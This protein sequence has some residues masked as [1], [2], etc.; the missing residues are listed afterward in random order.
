MG[1]ESAIREL[2]DE[3]PNTIISASAG[4]SKTFALSNLYLRLLSSG[5]ECQTIL[6]TTFTK[7]GAGEILDRIMDRLSDAALDDNAAAGLS[8]ELEWQLTQPQ[9]ATALHQL[10]KN[11]HRLE[12]GTLDS[13]FNRIAKLFSLELGLPPTWEIVEEQQ[14][15][16]LHDQAIQQVLQD[17][18]V[19]SLLHMLSKGE[20]AR[21]VATL[22]HDT[23]EQVYRI[24]RESGPAPW[25]RLPK[26]G[27]FLTDGQL[28]NVLARMESLELPGTALPK[29][30]SLVTEL[31]RTG[32]WAQ[33]ALT[34]SFQNVLDGKLKFGNAKLTPEMV[35]I[36]EE[37]R[38]HCTASIEQQLI[39]QNHSTRDLLM[40]FDNV[41]KTAKDATGD[42]GFDD[43]TER[44]QDFVR[45]W[46]A[47]RFS[48]RLDHQI[49]HLLL[50]EFQDTSLAQW[51]V[52]R[53]FARKVT[54]SRSAQRSFFCVGDMKQAIF[55]WRGGVAEIFDLVDSELLHLQK[56]ETLTKSYRSAPPVID[57]VNQVFLNVD[58][59]CS[60]DV[61]CDTAIK[62]WAQ[63]F[64]QHTTA[65]QELPGCV[66]IEMAADCAEFSKK[67]DQTKDSSRNAN[68][69]QKTI[70][71][72]QTL[73][74]TLPAQKTIGLIVRTNA[75]VGQLISY[76]QQAGISAS[77]EGGSAL[78]DS[79]AV[80]LILSAL[81]LADQPGDSLARFHVAQSPL[82]AM[83]GLI[84][85]TDANQSECAE[86][87]MMAAARLRCR[88]IT[89]GYG[90][91]VE[92]LA[93]VLLDRC[94]QRELSRLQQLVQVAYS[95][96]ANK[97][98]WQLRP[99]RFVGYV[100]ND[101]RVTDQSSAQVRV[102]TI[103]KAKGLEF[104]V[105]V[106]PIPVTSSGWAGLT[107][108]VVVGRESPTAPINVATRYVGEK[109]R[110]LL[111][112][113]FQRLFEHERQRNVREAMCVL[114]V[115]LTRAAHATH[116]I[117]S[118]GAKPDH[119]SAAGILL[120][121]VCPEVDRQEG[122]LYEQGDRDWFKAGMVEQVVEKAA[123][124]S[125]K[126]PRKNSGRKKSV[127]VASGAKKLNSDPYN[128]NQF[129]L[130]DA[131]E[132]GSS[133]ILNETRSGRGI[134]RTSPSLLEGGDRI[135]L[136]RIFQSA[137]AQAAMERGRQL[138]A[139]FELVKWLDQSIPTR[140]QL[141]DHLHRFSPTTKDFSSTIADFYR[142]IEHVQVQSLLNLKTYQELFMMHFPLPGPIL[143][144][145]QRLEVENERP[146]AVQLESGLLQG[147]IDRLVLIYEGDRLVAADVIDFKTDF[148]PQTGIQQLIEY[149]RPQLAGYR[150]A[151]SKFTRLPLEQIATRLV[152]VES[153]QLI[154]L[155]LVESE[156]SPNLTDPPPFRLP[157]GSNT[158]DSETDGLDRTT[159]FKKKGQRDTFVPVDRQQTFWPTD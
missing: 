118:H 11:L 96:S 129:Y 7:K 114:Y 58:K 63:W 28:E 49:Q 70:E 105:V 124:Q 75:E 148:V 153:G 92:S 131:A 44:L 13:F 126:L 55:G 95:S 117:V 135:Q 83:L 31:A 22:I 36:F 26:T 10:L 59:Y 137:G 127:D 32:D 115:A 16:R 147:V 67:E 52:I 27:Q 133:I 156:F 100:R 142:A 141:Q 108:N 21:R 17:E 155:D 110:K 113:G 138:H 41:L 48:F 151:V 87:A 85:E 82:G 101:V 112:A 143:L 43:V 42:L 4:T 51:N 72:V 116:V 46:D 14:M 106:L 60:G 39:Q 15:G 65:R 62:D 50:D 157:P 24:Y 76:L 79:A 9:A 103:H 71:R 134:P 54:E 19:V 78:T 111:P 125:T 152:F 34:T 128:L 94:T 136:K 144:E 45:K 37:L 33:F 8:V 2:A 140:Q 99:G 121:T 35:G 93:R 18:A 61:V 68:V 149:Y 145:A 84:A 64:S 123:K 150:A 130:D 56:A 12:I 23:V 88:L 47:D 73:K 53:P 102:M 30:W 107:P 86:S 91:V 1:N 98:L 159:H 25:D 89:E 132:L 158:S 90:P 74:Q 104:D 69:I 20:A 3:F 29:Q 109:L 5:A 38:P 122:L 80:E 146:F 81:S 97:D 57:L 139:C 66:T 40:A 119:K 6:A 77:E 154:N 120:A